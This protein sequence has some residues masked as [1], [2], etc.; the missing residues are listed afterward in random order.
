MNKSDSINIMILLL[1]NLLP[2]LFLVFSI[3]LLLLF[4][5]MMDVKYNFFILHTSYTAIMLIFIIV[6]TI[7]LVNVVDVDCFVYRVTTIHSRFDIF[8]RHI[9]IIFIARKKYQLENI[10]LLLE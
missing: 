3:S 9:L 10:L 5:L 7:I 1:T 6:L 2:E 4:V 8:I